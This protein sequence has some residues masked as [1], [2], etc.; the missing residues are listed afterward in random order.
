MV[1]Y[2]VTNQIQRVTATK[3]IQLINQLA[4][5]NNIRQYLNSR[6]IIAPT[7]SIAALIAF[8]S[9]YN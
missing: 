8:D 4:T 2:A 3:K 5:D 7:I 1:F 9:D 6:P